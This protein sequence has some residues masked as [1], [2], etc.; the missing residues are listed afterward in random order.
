MDS[1]K[2]CFCCG[3]RLT[4]NNR[5]PVADKGI[6][7]FVGTRLFPSQLPNNG[8]ICSKCRSMYNRWK[9]LP[10]FHDI[11]RTIYGGQRT[12]DTTADDISGEDEYMDEEN[13]SSSEVASDDESM[14][15]E[16]CS[17]QLVNET[18]SDNESIRDD[19]GE[20]QAVIVRSNDNQSIDEAAGD[21]GST[22]E[23]RSTDEG[24]EA[25]SSVQH[26]S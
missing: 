24:S 19:H 16:N 6:R 18:S 22:D 2:S 25:V 11:L 4:A 13:G 14:D 10:E 23:E 20:D 26:S 15:D 1:K 9:V 5:R 21:V 12:T 7:F 8:H 3:N 17:D